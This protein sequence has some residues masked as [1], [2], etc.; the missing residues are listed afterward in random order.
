MSDEYTQD[1]DL[2]RIDDIIDKT[3][4]KVCEKLGYLD[5]MKGFYALRNRIEELTKLTTCVGS[6]GDE[7]AYN[8]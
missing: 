1:V 4:D 8:D 3:V 6:C 5:Y 7:K 2:S